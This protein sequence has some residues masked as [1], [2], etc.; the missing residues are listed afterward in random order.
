MSAAPLLASLERSGALA[1]RS[2][3]K[4]GRSDT[5]D[6]LQVVCAIWL[7]AECAVPGTDVDYGAPPAQTTSSE[8]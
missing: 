2:S 8:T 7:R 4:R 3:H 5:Q 1:L 6:R